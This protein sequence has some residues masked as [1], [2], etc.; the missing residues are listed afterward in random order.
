MKK[1]QSRLTPRGLFVSITLALILVEPVS[2]QRRRPIPT[3]PTNPPS[4]DSTNNSR[5]NTRSAEQATMELN[6]LLSKRSTVADL[7]RQRQRAATQLADNL[8]QLERINNERL[9]PIASATPIDYKNLAQASAELKAKATRIKFYSPVLL[10]DKTGQKIRYE[11]DPNQLPTMLSQLSRAVTKFVDNPVFRINAPN[12]Q[13]LRSAAAHEL[14]A[15]IKL[16]DTI[17][18]ISKRLSKPLVATR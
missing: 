6:V 5:A 1:I 3:P 14:D 16:S 13:E 17:S 2:A 15:I 18:K 4:Q 12:D 10:I 9:I 11:E 7:E 8:E